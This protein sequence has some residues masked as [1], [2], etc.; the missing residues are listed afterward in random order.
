MTDKQWKLK[1]DKASIFIRE[2]AATEA[3]QRFMCEIVEK[4]PED[5]I[6]VEL[7]VC[8]GMTSALLS[9]S[10]RGRYF[11][12]DHFLMVGHY[13][14]IV[15]NFNKLGITNYE[16]LVGNTQDVP[17][18]RPIDFLFIDA[19]HDENNVKPDCEKWI[20]FVKPGGYVAFHDWLGCVDK[21]LNPHWAVDYYGSLATQGWEDIVHIENQLK[22]K[23]RPL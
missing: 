2:Y 17:W 11:G 23:R 5:S 3:Q 21:E 12:V 10:T 14:E 8:Y 22:I 1:L 6:T 4:L 18:D 19:G 15:D 13:N 9:M 20:P 7:G 16:F